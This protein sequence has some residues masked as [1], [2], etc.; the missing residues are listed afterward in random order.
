M[1]SSIRPFNNKGYRQ[2]CLDYLPLIRNIIIPPLNTTSEFETVFID[3]RWLPHIEY[4]VRNTI[5]K[6]PNWR[7]TIVCGNHNIE[8]I[9]HMCENISFHINIIHLDI[10][11]CSIQEYSNLLLSTDFW[12]KLTG[13][14]I[15]L[16][17]EDTFL[18]HG[19]IEPFLKYDYIGAPWPH[20]FLY[21]V[22]NGGF[23]LRTREILITI[24]EKFKP[25]NKLE[26]NEDIFFCKNMFQ[27]KIGLIAPKH[28]ALQFA[29]EY[30]IGNNPL[31][32]HKF[33]YDEFSPVPSYKCLSFNTKSQ[34][35]LLQYG[36]QHHVFNQCSEKVQLN[37]N[38]NTILS[39]GVQWIALID[40]KVT[41]TKS[42]IHRLTD[43]L[44]II[45]ISKYASPSKITNIVPE[46]TIRYPKTE[47]ELRLVYD[48]MLKKINN[49]I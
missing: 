4:L 20:D 33:Y 46:Y 44:C 19:N 49:L 16:Y 41:W 24:L 10:N 47:Q 34:N 36:V 14:K 6:L 42:I 48:F 38:L 9:I 30:I 11:E 45:N 43:C 3:F 5:I 7:H 13:K 25:Q 2:K 39:K 37:Y 17:Q 28:I 22:G 1:L 21:E 35:K 8:Q 23:S 29:E 27:S 18:F 26:L 12:D 40:N 15:L 31:G 32:G